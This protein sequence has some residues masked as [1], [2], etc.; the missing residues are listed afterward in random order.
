MANVVPVLLEVTEFSSNPFEKKSRSLLS[1]FGY[2]WHKKLA[3]VFVDLLPELSSKN[4]AH[5]SVRTGQT[6]SLSAAVVY[7]LQLTWLGPP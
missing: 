3:P 7:F 1:S 2:F 6:T 4:V 5:R